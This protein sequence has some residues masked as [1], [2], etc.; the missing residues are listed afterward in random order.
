MDYAEAVHGDRDLGPADAGIPHCVM[1][2]EGDGQLAGID[3]TCDAAFPIVPVADF[4]PVDPD[5]VPALLKVRLKRS[6]S[7]LVD[8]MAVAEEDGLRACRAF[9]QDAVSR[10]RADC[11]GNAARRHC[12]PIARP[13]L[14]RRC[15]CCRSGGR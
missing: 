14:S 11:P 6:T 13:W 8:V 7:S 15:R 3:A 10:F 2:N 5:L 12:I 4:L 1:C 9:A